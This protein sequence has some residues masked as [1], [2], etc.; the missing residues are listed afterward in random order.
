MRLL[1]L[2]LAAASASA[3][4]QPG[5]RPLFVAAGLGASGRAGA[6][7][8]PR[9]Y[10]GNLSVTALL[11]ARGALAVGAAYATELDLLGPSDVFYEAHVAYGVLASGRPGVASIVAGPALVLS[12]RSEED[13]E[14]V[15]RVRLG[16]YVGVQGILKV[17]GDV[18]IG[19]EVFA[20]LSPGL[21]TV[22]A[23]IV[24]ATGRF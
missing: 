21:S 13:R 12:R 15:E 5:E 4:A 8:V 10:A 7:A 23:R 2:L 19:T 3:S 6:S 24:V 11:S 20:Q 9:F 14:R 22:G 18:G 17:G 16:A 1:V